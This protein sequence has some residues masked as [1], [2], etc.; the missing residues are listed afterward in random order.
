MSIQ[1]DH[2]DQ[3]ILAILQQDCTL[4]LNEIA[5]IVNLS[6][7]PCWRRIKRLE[8]LQVILKRVALV[9]G[10]KLNRGIVVFVH[11]RTNQHNASWLAQFQESVL[12]IPEVMEAYR[13]AGEWDY[14]LKVIVEDLKH[15]DT[16]YKDL[17]EKIALHDVTST[18]AMEQMK[19]KTNIEIP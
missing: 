8:E 12:P 2:T 14:M 13:L 6:P 17:V 5:D 1:L 10:A 11:L 16:F 18:F 15:F 3:K 7:T 4:S 9:D 19:Y